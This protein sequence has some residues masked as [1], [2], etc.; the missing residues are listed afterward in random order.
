M[1]YLTLANG[2]QMPIL[3]F[4]TYLITDAGECTRSVATAVENGYRLI[5]TAQVYGNE[6]AVGEAIRA[7]GI[8]RDELFLITKLWFDSYETTAAQRAIGESLKKLGTDYLDM[9]LLHWPY[10]DT[11]AAWRVLEEFHERGVI[12]ALGVSNYTPDRLVDLMHFHR[13]APVLNQIEVNLWCQRQAECPWHEK[14]GVAMQA[15]APMGRKRPP[16]YFDDPVLVDLGQKYNKSVRQ[17]MLRFLI[18]NGVAVIPKSVHPER[19]RENIQVFDFSLNAQEMAMLATF[20]RAE[21]LIGDPQN[22]NRVERLL[23]K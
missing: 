1:E 19:I 18:Q 14:L 13:V 6:A 4:G 9:V 7:C 2:M 21:P 16:E 17:I 5:D 15:Y 23:G 11:Y 8:P 22:P 20:D 3:G 10:G 12:R